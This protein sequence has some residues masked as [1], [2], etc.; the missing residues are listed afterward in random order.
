MDNTWTCKLL[1][2]PLSTG[3]ISIQHLNLSW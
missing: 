1:F 2:T 3:W